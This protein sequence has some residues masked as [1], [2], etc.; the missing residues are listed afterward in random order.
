MR[1]EAGGQQQRTGSGGSQKKSFVTSMFCYDSMVE[2][3]VTPS[4]A[5]KSK[6]A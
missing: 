6:P 2:H 3:T 1:F 5:E 4:T